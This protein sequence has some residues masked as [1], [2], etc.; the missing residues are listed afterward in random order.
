MA[1]GKGGSQSVKIPKYLEEAAQRN[2]ARADY[3]SSLG[4]VDYSGPDVAA[5]TPLQLAAI[6]GTGQAASAFGLSGGGVTGTEGMPVATEMP[7]GGMAYSSF[8]IYQ[9]AKD[10]LA[11]RAPGQYDAIRA[12][13]IDPITGAAPT[14]P[15]FAPYLVSAA[16]AAGLPVSYPAGGD[17]GYGMDF[18]VGTGGSGFQGTNIGDRLNDISVA[19]GGKGF[20]AGIKGMGI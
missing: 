17:G 15:Q 20:G 5:M 3:I 9:Q 2:L 11:A 1:G 14:A 13:Y 4:L 18:G 19:L 16:P 8:P 7:G 12:M 6:Q 10:E